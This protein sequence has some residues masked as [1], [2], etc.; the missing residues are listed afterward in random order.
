MSIK[1]IKVKQDNKTVHLASIRVRKRKI[2]FDRF[3]RHRFN[4]SLL[5]KQW[6]LAKEKEFQQ[7]YENLLAGN[8][9][10]KKP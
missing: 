7:E 6:A 10:E 1:I 3:E 5:A 8:P 9:V 4:D 2:P